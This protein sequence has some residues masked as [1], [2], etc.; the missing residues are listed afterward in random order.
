MKVPSSLAVGHAI[1]ALRERGRQ[2]LPQL[3]RAAT[4]SPTELASI[5]A[6]RGH[7][8]I[9]TLHRVARALG[10]TLVELVHDAGS[11]ANGEG[12]LH[13]RASKPSAP[14][15]LPD[16]A[17][18]IAEL[19][20]SVGSKVDA[21]ESA[22]VLHAMEIS[23]DNQSAA[24]RLLGMERKAFVRRLARAKRKS[25]PAAKTRKSRS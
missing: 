19:P 15:A 1:R 20:D 23:G 6:G 10:S 5:E 2:S 13:P 4:V 7:P 22:T 18:A 14:L 16:I 3:A 12:T 8:T 9:A 25:K 11:A 17:R 24:A 21:A